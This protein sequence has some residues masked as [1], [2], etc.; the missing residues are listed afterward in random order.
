MTGTP[1]TRGGPESACRPAQLRRTPTGIERSADGNRYSAGVPA[2][3]E[4]PSGQGGPGCPL[5]GTPYSGRIEDGLAN[6]VDPE[7]L[8]D[9]RVGQPHDAVGR[10]AAPGGRQAECLAHVAGLHEGGPIGTGVGIA[11]ENSLE[12]GSEEDHRR[13]VREITRCWAGTRASARSA[14]A[15]RPSRGSAGRPRSDRCQPGGPGP[16]GPRHSTRWDAGPSGR[17]CLEGRQV[18]VCLDPLL[19]SS[20]ESQNCR[21]LI[22]T[23]G[24]RRI[25]P[26]RPA[27]LQDLRKL[28]GRLRDAADR[29]AQHLGIA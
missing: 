12:D 17:R 6:P 4:G 21:Q 10:Q 23:N 19:H 2:G 24:R 14:R 13:G 22:Q 29:C 11:P 26:P 15:H 27:R 3:L 9:Q 28:S 18:P 5:G 7:V 8:L 25:P 16:S 20:G 1:G